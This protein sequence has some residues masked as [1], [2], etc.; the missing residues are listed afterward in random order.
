MLVIMFYTV[1][2]LPLE[3]FTF[4]AKIEVTPYRHSSVAA[5]M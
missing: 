4:R 1:W 2:L 3:K 5:L